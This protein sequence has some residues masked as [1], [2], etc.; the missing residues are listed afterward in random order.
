MRPPINFR[1]FAELWL[2]LVHACHAI[3]VFLAYLF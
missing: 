2:A 1:E 3:G